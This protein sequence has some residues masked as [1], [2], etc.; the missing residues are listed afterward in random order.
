MRAAFFLHQNIFPGFSTVRIAGTF[1]Q[2]A[3]QQP[4]RC[5]VQHVRGTSVVVYPM[6]L[7]ETSQAPPQVHGVCAPVL[8]S[9][10][11]PRDLV[12]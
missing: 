2:L 3:R 12:G 4:H 5:L 10:S 6:V 11:S 9:S 8:W 7:A 1:V